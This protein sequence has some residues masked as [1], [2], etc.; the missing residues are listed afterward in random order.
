MALRVN[1]NVAALNALRHLNRT[2][3]ELS[4]NLERL[5][6]GRRLNKAADGPAALVISEQMK[7]QISSIRRLY[8]WTRMLAM[9]GVATA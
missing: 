9:W 4:T 1:T 5:S 7:S 8:G 6:S 2:E 3:Q